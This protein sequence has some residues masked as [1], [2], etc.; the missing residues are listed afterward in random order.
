MPA[1]DTPEPLSATVEF[2]LGTARIVASKRLDT[3]VSVLPTDGRKGADVKAAEQTEVTCG[4]GRLVVKGPKQRS[5]FGK[6]GSLEITI[7][8]PAGSDVRGVVAAGSFTAEGRLGDCRFECAAGDI[9]VAEVG[10]A[11][12]KTESGNVRMDRATGDAEVQAA[13]RVDV[14]SIVGAATVKNLRGAINLGEVT[15]ELRISSTTGGV[16]VGLAHGDVEATSVEGPIKVREVVRG[17]VNLTATHGDLEVGINQASA[18][19]LETNSMAG[20]TRNLMGSTDGTGP[21]AETVK[22]HARTTVGDV[23]IRRA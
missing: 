19:W 18:A 23:V 3:V 21:G 14:G 10:A 17:Q 22:V 2:D 6:S 13:G 11:F 20:T 9:S 12:L 16:S 7:E 1:F 8:L 4:N 15:G 5:I